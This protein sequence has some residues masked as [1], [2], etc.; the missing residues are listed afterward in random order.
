MC[1]VALQSCTLVISSF[2]EIQDSDGIISFASKS[3]IWQA[4]VALLVVSAKGRELEA[5]LKEACGCQTTSLLA[6]ELNF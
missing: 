2:L 6:R 5:S 3:F 4:D 1:N